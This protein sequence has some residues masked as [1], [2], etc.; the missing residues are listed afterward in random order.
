[1]IEM[2]CSVFLRNPICVSK[3]LQWYTVKRINPRLSLII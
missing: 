1:V 2:K 3:R